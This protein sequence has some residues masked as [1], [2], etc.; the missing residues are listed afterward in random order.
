MIMPK[1]I[2]N[3]EHHNQSKKFVTIIFTERVLKNQ[4]PTFVSISSINGTCLS[5]SCK[6]SNRWVM[7]FFV[8]NSIHD[9]RKRKKTNFVHI[10]CQ[11]L[12]SIQT[13]WYNVQALIL[14]I[15]NTIKMRMHSYGRKLTSNLMRFVFSSGATCLFHFSHFIFSPE[16]TCFFAL[17]KK[18]VTEVPIWGLFKNKNR[19]R[20]KVLLVRD[21]ENSLERAM[22]NTRVEFDIFVRCWRC[23]ASILFDCRSGPI[24]NRLNPLR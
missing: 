17:L 3:Y 19:F 7:G 13:F 10:V 1:T 24:R 12:Q 5:T 21:D 18:I 23:P 14:S 15:I 2:V 22:K 8:F 20:N 16:L 11:I 9:K 6:E 4:I